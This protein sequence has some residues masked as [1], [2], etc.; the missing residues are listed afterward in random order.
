MQALQTI[1]CGTINSLCDRIVS[2]PLK[3]Y[4]AGTYEKK[5]EKL[6]Y[7]EPRRYGLLFLVAG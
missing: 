1:M 7:I 5:S 4:H 2:N 6:H 3:P